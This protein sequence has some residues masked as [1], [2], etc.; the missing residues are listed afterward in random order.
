METLKFRPT[1][2]GIFILVMGIP[3]CGW[4]FYVSITPLPKKIFSLE[5]FIT[6]AFGSFSFICTMMFIYY[7]FKIKFIRLDNDSLT[8]IYPLLFRKITIPF[9]HISKI[10]DEP[11]IIKVSTRSG[12]STFFEGKRI[13]IQFENKKIDIDSYQTKD[14][15]DLYNTLQNRIKNK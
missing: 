6:F 8:I 15:D 11:Q 5:T 12:V 7:F 10:E 2:R 13:F 3:L 4:L 9:S 14:F 1:I